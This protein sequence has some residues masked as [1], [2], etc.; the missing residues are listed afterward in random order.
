[1]RSELILP[2]IGG[3]TLDR[4][5]NDTLAIYRRTRSTAGTIYVDDA[6]GNGVEHH[7]PFPAVPGF[8]QIIVGQDEQLVPISGTLTSQPRPLAQVVLPPRFGQNRSIAPLQIRVDI[9]SNH[10]PVDLQEILQYR[11]VAL[12]GDD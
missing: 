11:C 5:H 10:A 3:M 6:S 12:T 4:I 1:M 8:D 2:H 9:V 7:D